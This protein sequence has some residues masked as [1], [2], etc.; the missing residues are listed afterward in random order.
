MDNA[1][2]TEF[3]EARKTFVQKKY[4]PRHKFDFYHNET[5]CTHA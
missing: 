4:G 5:M 1:N 2:C 3:K